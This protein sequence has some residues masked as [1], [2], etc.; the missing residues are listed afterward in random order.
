[1]FSNSKMSDFDPRG[2]H[3]FI[4]ASP[5]SPVI[6]IYIKQNKKLMIESG[7]SEDLIRFLLIVYLKL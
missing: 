1:M 4:M 5:L 2:Q 3:F 7:A 6:E